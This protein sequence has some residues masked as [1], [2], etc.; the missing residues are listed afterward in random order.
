M[1][2]TFLDANNILRHTDRFPN[3][4]LKLGN[5]LTRGRV[6]FGTEAISTSF[7]L[8][9]IDLGVGA[10]NFIA[11]LIPA[12]NLEADTEAAQED[13]DDQEEEESSA[14]IRRRWT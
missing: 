1:L 8:V 4:D 9:Q 11:L 14:V 2:L 6:S 5:V 3:S 13:D 10:P 7:L 12:P